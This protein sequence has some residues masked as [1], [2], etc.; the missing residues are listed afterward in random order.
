MA[1]IVSIALQKGGVGK[2]TTCVNMAAVLA[3][4]GKKVLIVDFDPQGNASI[5]YGINPDQEDKTIYDVFSNGAEIKD[6]IKK[7]KFLVDIV[8]AN[9][10]LSQLDLLIMSNP[11]V[12]TSPAFVLKEVLEEIEI[13]YEYILIDLPPSLS[14]LTVNALTASTDVLIPMQ[15]EYLATSGVNKLLKTIEK[16]KEAYNP[17]IKILGIIPT[18]YNTKTN[19]SSVVLQEARKFFMKNGIRVFETT[20][21]RSIK[22]AEAPMH[23]EPAVICFPENEQA[24]NYVELTREVFDV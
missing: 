16:V 24:Q 14:I 21:Y 5:S 11:E 17:G 10:E 8:P 20:I 7:T 4:Q 13:E 12:F 3:Q 2:T 19:L 22:I 15:T 9:D 23:G 1:R 6:I 18:M